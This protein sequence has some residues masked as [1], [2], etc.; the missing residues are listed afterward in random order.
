L[1]LLAVSFIPF[2]SVCLCIGSIVC[3]V[4]VDKAFEFKAIYESLALGLQQSPHAESLCHGSVSFVC[5]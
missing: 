3:I 4:F 1:V 2:V 5:F